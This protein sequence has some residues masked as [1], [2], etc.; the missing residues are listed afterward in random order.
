VV[1]VGGI[2]GGATFALF[3]A[4]SGNQ[5]QEFEAGTVE[6]AN[7]DKT[8]WSS[9]VGNMAPGDTFEKKITVTNTGSLQLA[10]AATVSKSGD[11]FKGATPATVEI[12][13][14]YGI[15]NPGA[16]TT[17]TAR[18]AL[19]L[20][21]KNEYQTLNG[22]FEIT[23][24]AYQTKNVNPVPAGAHKT[25]NNAYNSVRDAYYDGYEFRDGGGNLIPLFEDNLLA[26]YE[27]R[28]GGAI[29]YLVAEGNTDP[30]FWFNDAKDDGHYDY[31]LVLKS[32]AV[33]YSGINH[34]G[35]N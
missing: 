30:K 26:M 8:T 6:I 3:S 25:N 22:Q 4:S 5:K 9:E 19:P 32:G 15:L 2:V 31:V 7:S 11:L 28:P 33:Y 1:L 27:R 29:H 13:N 24:H 18:V 10:F 21:A 23:F 20:G 12:G 34:V 16:S 17:V 35:D 14:A